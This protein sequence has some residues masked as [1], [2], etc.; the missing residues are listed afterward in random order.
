MNI[1]VTVAV[2]YLGKFYEIKRNFINILHR[3]TKSDNSME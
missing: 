1:P 3:T 2:G